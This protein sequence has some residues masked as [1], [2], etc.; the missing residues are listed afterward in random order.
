MTCSTQSLQ[1]ISTLTKKKFEKRYNLKYDEPK[2]RFRILDDYLSQKYF[3]NI[4]DLSIPVCQFAD[5]QIDTEKVF[6]VENEMNMLTF[7]K[8]KNSIV[9]WGHGFGVE[10]MKQ[11][12]WL[13]NKTIYYWGDLDAQGFQILSQ[14]RTYFKQV[15]SFMMDRKTF[16]LYYDDDKGS[17]T[18][19]ENL[20]SL[21][22]DEYDTFKYLRDNNL[23]LEQEKIPYDYVIDIIQKLA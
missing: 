9:I 6:I 14:I 4:N 23:R 8:V 19:S 12:E 16:D 21:T 11:V 13:H 5:L 10:I 2:V 20:S 18:K 7:P 3:S 1:T 22:S 17:E 15:E